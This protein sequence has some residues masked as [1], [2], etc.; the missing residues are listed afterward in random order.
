MQTI[1]TSTQ[2]HLDVEDIVNNLVFLKDKTAAMVLSISAVNFNLLSEEEQDAIIYAYASLLN[3]LSFPIQILIRSQRKDISH[4]LK[5][6]E[7]QEQRQKDPLIKKRILQ[8]RQFIAQ[9]VKERNVLDKKFFIILPFSYTD[10]GINPSTLPIPGRK[11]APSIDKN[12][13]M[14]KV[15]STLEP[16]RDHLLRQLGNLGLAAKQLNTQQLIQLLY[17]I[18]NPDAADGIQTISTKQYTSPMV[19][20]NTL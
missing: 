12:Y 3:S 9:I 19:Q 4:Y 17:T 10:L 13:L 16:R 2:E 6:L 15:V 7:S 14:Q 18:Y 1:K 8:Y 20:A 5:L 11:V